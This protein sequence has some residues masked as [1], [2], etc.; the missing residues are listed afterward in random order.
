MLPNTYANERLI[1]TLIPS[2]NMGQGVGQGILF[3][4]MAIVCVF[5]CPYTNLSPISS[6]HILLSFP[7][8]NIPILCLFYLLIKLSVN[9]LPFSRYYPE[10]F[11]P[12]KPNFL[13]I[14]MILALSISSLPTYFA[15][16]SSLA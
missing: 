15:T 11:L 3:L 10:A 16:Y 5:S 8:W 7:I 13:G 12:S 2:S 1:F 6:M 4:F 14:M 9:P